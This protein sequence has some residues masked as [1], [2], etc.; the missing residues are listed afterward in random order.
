MS[1]ENGGF[2]VPAPPGPINSN[3]TPQDIAK[4]NLAITLLTAARAAENVAQQAA[5]HSGQAALSTLQ[6]YNDS[7]SDGPETAGA[8]EPAPPGTGSEVLRAA[9]SG[10][11]NHVTKSLHFDWLIVFC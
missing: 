11:L 2:V 7:D 6:A 3:R 8:A 9:R 10:I 4:Q 5:K 1:S